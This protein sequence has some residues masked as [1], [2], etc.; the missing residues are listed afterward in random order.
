MI[1]WKLLLM[2]IVCTMI[3]LDV[4]G[5]CIVLALLPNKVLFLLAVVA[6]VCMII[7]AFYK[8]LGD[9]SKKNREDD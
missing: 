9:N 5:V 3:L 8:T 1:N 2:A 6:I 7:S 4:F